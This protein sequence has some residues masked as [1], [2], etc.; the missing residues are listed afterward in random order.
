M[1]QR[2]KYFEHPTFYFIY[3]CF[4]LVQHLNS[5]SYN[6]ELEAQT[7]FTPNSL[8]GVLIS[9]NFELAP[10]LFQIQTESSSMLSLSTRSLLVIHHQCVYTTLD[11]T[12]PTV[13]KVLFCSCWRLV[14]F[15]FMN[16]GC[17]REKLY[18]H[19][20]HSTAKLYNKIII[21]HQ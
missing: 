15:I 19:Q 10:T 16:M 7:M 17:C 5:N 12:I 3:G 13:D 1:R 2:M 6:D 20:W 18:R 9:L 11:P 21:I 14:K 8:G 4:F